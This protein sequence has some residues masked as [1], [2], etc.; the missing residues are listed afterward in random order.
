MVE[1]AQ[2]PTGGGLS[3]EPMTSTELSAVRSETAQPFPCHYSTLEKAMPGD[4]F[5][6]L[7]MP[8]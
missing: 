2:L 3:M 4:F 1:E 5:Y 8:V 7:I 6:S